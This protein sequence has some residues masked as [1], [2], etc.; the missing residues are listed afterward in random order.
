MLK[1]AVL[2]VP[3]AHKKQ[4]RDYDGV[5]LRVPNPVL[6]FQLWRVQPAQPVQRVQQQ[7]PNIQNVVMVEVVP[8]VFRG[9]YRSLLTRFIDQIFRDGLASRSFLALLEFRIQWT[10][11]TRAHIKLFTP[12]CSL[13]LL[14]LFS[15][16]FR[17]SQ[18]LIFNIYHL[19][20]E[21]MNACIIIFT[22]M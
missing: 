6:L 9:D 18:K 10:F 17:K 8:S 12:G 19:W 4:Q 7:Q 1:T 5:F 14:E 15:F 13:E 20:K 11:L 3:H 22:Q 2:L 21:I 16:F